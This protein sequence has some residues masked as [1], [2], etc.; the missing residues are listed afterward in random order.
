MSARAF[1]VT[2]KPMP[3]M[4][5]FVIANSPAEAKGL[6]ARTLI[7]HGYGH[8]RDVFRGLSVRRRPEKDHL[9]DP[10]RAPHWCGE[11]AP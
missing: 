4:V 6:V 7:E 9:A 3:D 11:E 1:A 5:G 10:L 2:W 8:P